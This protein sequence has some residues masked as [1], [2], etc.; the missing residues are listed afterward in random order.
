MAPR[1]KPSSNEARGFY[2]ASPARRVISA[3]KAA[4]EQRET[5][6]ALEDQRLSN[7]NDN[8]TESIAS[9]NAGH[10]SQADAIADLRAR[11]NTAEANVSNLIVANQARAEQIQALA[12]RVALLEDQMPN[13]VNIAHLGEPAH[14]VH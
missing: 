11:L 8:K 9:L 1:R 10:Q 13:K 7:A 3:E 14:H 12:G 4:R 6:L 2:H 5:E